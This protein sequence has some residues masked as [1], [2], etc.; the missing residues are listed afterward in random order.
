MS[1][2]KRLKQYREKAGLSLEQLADA[3]R[4]S[5][6]YIWELENDESE[7]KKPSAEMLMRI[8]DALSITL[9]ELLGLPTITVKKEKVSISKSLLE[10]KKQME[11]LGKPLS[12]EDLKGLAGMSFRGGQ[13]RSV[14]EW[15]DLFLTLD[16]ISKR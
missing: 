6:G 16:R 5:K 7:K 10:F 9:A 13:P 2:A 1:L 11:L 14:D 15:H 3:A 12:D 8:A 4:T